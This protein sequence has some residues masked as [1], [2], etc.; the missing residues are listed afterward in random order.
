MTSQDFNQIHLRIQLC[1]QNYTHTG[2]NAYHNEIKREAVRFVD[3]IKPEISEIIDKLKS[4]T[5]GCGVTEN[6][7]ISKRDAINLNFLKDV[8]IDNENITQ[9]KN[10]ILRIIAGAIMNVYL[11][12]LFPNQKS[13]NKVDSNIF[14]N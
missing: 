13:R 11:E 6:F 12:S 14:L 1:I 10:D 8:G 4:R 2:I 9:I 7:L 5:V 3:T